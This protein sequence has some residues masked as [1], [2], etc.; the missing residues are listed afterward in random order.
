MNDIKYVWKKEN[1]LFGVEMQKD[2]DNGMYWS[3][4]TFWFKTEIARTMFVC[5]GKQSEEATTPNRNKSDMMSLKSYLKD[6]III[7]SG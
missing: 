6:A 4:M 5:A 1:G 3:Y 7:T 2:M